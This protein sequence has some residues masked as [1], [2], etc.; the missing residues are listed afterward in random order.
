MGVLIVF[1][2]GPGI[3]HA[4]AERFGREG[5]S[6]A[7]VA[8]NAERLDE[9][10]ARLKADGIDAVAYR[11]DARDPEMIRQTV[12]RV[13]KDLGTVS[14]VLWTAF[15]SGGVTDVLATRPEDV[16]RVFDVGIIGLLTCV[17]EVLD[18]LRSSPGA[19]VLVANGSVG[20]HSSESDAFTKLLGIDGVALENAAKSKLVG[21]LAERLRDSG[22]HVGE[23]TI[24]GSVKGT[25][26]ASPTAI[27]PSLIAETFWSLVRD[28]DRTRVRMTE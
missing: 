26:T 6:L 25:P 15:R 12:S 19:A 20:E 1:G 27:E 17:Q 9:G 7:L 10:V 8:R 22:V 13:R 21:V 2:Y 16:A 3:S 23:V 24:A 11:S 5:Y 18:D 14:A 4:T 28:R